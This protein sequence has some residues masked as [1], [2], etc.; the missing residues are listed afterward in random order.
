VFQ[1]GELADMTSTY[2]AAFEAR[3][4]LSRYES[5]SLLLFA[6]LLRFDIQDIEAVANQSLTDGSDDKKCDLVYLDKDNQ[7]AVV[8]QGYYANSGDLNRE[9][10]ANKASDLNTAVTWLLANPLDQLPTRIQSAAAELREALSNQEIQ[11]LEFWYSHNLN[12]SQN[13]QNELDAVCQSAYRIV[14][15]EFPNINEINIVGREI[16][17][18]AIEELYQS[19]TTPILVTDELRIQLEGGFEV[20][21][22]EWN[23]FITVIPAKWLY[24]NFQIYRSR[25]FSANIRGYLGSRNVDANI[26]NG[27]KKT[28][29]SDP[30]NFCVYNNGLTAITNS[31]SYDQESGMLTLAG[32]SIVNGA[33]TTGS[34][35]NLATPPNDDAKVQARFIVCSSTPTIESIIRFNN[36]Q[37]KV[38]A[39]DFR[40]NDKI[41]TR[42]VEEFEGIPDAE[43]LGGRRGGAEDTIRRRANLLPSSTV[44]QALTAFHG[45]PQN[46]YNRKSDIWK[47]NSLYSKVFREETTAKHIVF[48]YSLHK[49][50][51]SFKRELLG[52][53][54]QNALTEA[55]KEQ[56]A[57]FQHG[58][59]TML[60][61]TAI[62]SCLEIVL[63][64]QVPDSFK[65]SFGDI[66]PD[67]AET[68]WQEV[69]EPLIA[70]ISALTPAV[71][72]GLKGQEFTNNLIRTSFRPLVNATKT[73][74]RPIY[75]S[76]K[77]KVVAS[78]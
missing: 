69:L 68:N 65:L 6:L 47:S 37:N 60:A 45:D 11:V 7:T 78:E 48:V 50:L 54:K 29:Q 21:A 3:T 70:L 58:G 75:N 28:A 26:N 4:D 57:F 2:Q 36:S 55:E 10:P 77:S 24:E 67:V 1:Y 27:I 18:N 32:V 14:R 53:S 63:E 66:S 35:G 76:F 38:E 39:P 12:E 22:E 56:L 41:Q 51:D 19:L 9:A 15:Q 8:A 40:S 25:L 16:G 20:S 34:I 42:L 17:S 71:E 33:Q 61:T 30:G 31:Y 72:N 64:Q 62:S 13:V 23:S 59:A 74:N 44:G 43:Y 49:A 46:A 5:N 73:P 52:K